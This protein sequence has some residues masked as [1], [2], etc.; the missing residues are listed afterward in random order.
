MPADYLS[1]N[2]VNAVS[3]DSDELAKAQDNDSM[4]KAMK[5]YLLHRELPAD[6]KCLQIIKHLADDCFIENDVVWRRVKRRFEPSRVVIFLP[7]S[8][9]PEVLQDAHGHLLGGHDGFLKTKERI[10][11]CYYWPGMDQDIQDHIQSCHK[12]QVRKPKNPTSPSLITSLP[13]PTEPNQRVHADLF[14]PLKT[15]G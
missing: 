7:A 9:V 11:Q 6:R 12:C 1:R 13:Q 8:L 4:L 14:G 10:F 3:W 5:R 15:S 2:V